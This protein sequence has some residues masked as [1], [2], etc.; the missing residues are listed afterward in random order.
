MLNKEDSEEL[1]HSEDRFD[2]KVRKQTNPSF[3]INI[4]EFSKL[5]NRIDSDM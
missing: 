5:S 1:K 4:P 3:L 2:M